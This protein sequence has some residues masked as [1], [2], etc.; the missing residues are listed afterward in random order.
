MKQAWCNY[1]LSRVSEATSCERQGGT[2]STHG[3]RFVHGLSP[4]FFRRGIQRMLCWGL[5]QGR[6]YW[7]KCLSLP[8]GK[9]HLLGGSA[10]TMEGAG[11]APRRHPGL[12]ARVLP[13]SPAWLTTLTASAMAQGIPLC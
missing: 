10:S 8:R 5:G 7:A 6:V 3:I 1:S 4:A 2:P 9:A 11:A 12:A 13:T